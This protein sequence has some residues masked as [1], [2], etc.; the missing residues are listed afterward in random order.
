MQSLRAKDQINIRR[1]LANGRAFLRGHTTA[2]ANH[3]LRTG[4]LERLPVAELGEDLL[5]RAFA[6]RTGVQQQH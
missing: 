2:H 1:A 4:A 3:H 6:D 5:L